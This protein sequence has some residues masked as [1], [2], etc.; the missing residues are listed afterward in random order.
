MSTM[1]SARRTATGIAPAARPA[2]TSSTLL[3]TLP[4]LTL[5]SLLLPTRGVLAG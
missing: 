4:L 3:L 1:G 2:Y 5:G